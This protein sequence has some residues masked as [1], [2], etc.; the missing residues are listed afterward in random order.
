MFLLAHGLVCFRISHSWR[1]LC[2]KTFLC[3]H[4]FWYFRALR[5]K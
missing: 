5:N 4:K 3:P 2:F 1:V